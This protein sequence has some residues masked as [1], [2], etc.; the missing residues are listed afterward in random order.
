MHLDKI[1]NWYKGSASE[2][3]VGKVKSRQILPSNYYFSL[4]PCSYILT[5]KVTCWLARSLSRHLST[6]VG[7]GILSGCV[8]PGIC[9]LPI[10]SCFTSVGWAEFRDC[11]LIF[12]QEPVFQQS[13][14]ETKHYSL[15]F[16]LWSSCLWL[17][18]CLVSGFCLFI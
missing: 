9:Q 12:F 1:S 13:L 4:N 14:E 15:L 8:T 3:S 2:M 11:P 6:V 10:C 17:G 7:T 5:T 18:F 16:W